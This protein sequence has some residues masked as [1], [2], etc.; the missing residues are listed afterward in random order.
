MDA[1][2]MRLRN[3]RKQNHSVAPTVISKKRRQ[4]AKEKTI[5]HTW[6]STVI[7]EMHEREKKNEIKA[8]K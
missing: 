8:R 2:K 4:K 5:S 7:A 3:A 6:H 1:A